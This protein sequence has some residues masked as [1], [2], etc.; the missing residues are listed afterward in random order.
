VSEIGNTISLQ[1]QANPAALQKE[2]EKDEQKTEKVPMHKHLDQKV[3]GFL[4]NSEASDKNNAIDFISEKPQQSEETENKLQIQTAPSKDPANA[5]AGDFLHAD[6][7]AVQQAIADTAMAQSSRE[8]SD[9]ATEEASGTLVKMQKIIM[10]SLSKPV[11]KE[12]PETVGSALDRLT[13]SLQRS[14]DA[15][16]N[17]DK[18]LSHTHPEVSVGGGFVLDL[19]CGSVSFDISNLLK[20]KASQESSNA[21]IDAL[22]ANKTEKMYPSFQD[23]LADVGKVP[24][25]IGPKKNI[26]IIKKEAWA[27][28]NA[29][30]SKPSMISQAHQKIDSKKALGLLH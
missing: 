12:N 29:V 10:D 4:H 2:A 24:T 17:V 19:I 11:S 22:K 7:N 21:F 20:E 28:L 9:T 15:I 6:K 25:E 14:L 3:E 13:E 27:A 1:F 8:V 30:M 5:A 16:K 23:V 18:N 26:A